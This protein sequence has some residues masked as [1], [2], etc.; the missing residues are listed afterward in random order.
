[1][2]KIKLM[3]LVIAGALVL[4][5]CNAN[6]NGSGKYSG[7]GSEHGGN[8]G[9]SGSNNVSGSWSDA[10]KAIFTNNLY[11]ID[12][13]Y[14]SIEGATALTYDAENEYASKTAPNCTKS[15]LQDYASLFDKS[16]T[17][18]CVDDSE[19]ETYYICYEKSVST[20][21]GTRYVD[22][23]MYGGTYDDELEDY[24]VN[25]DGS[26]TFIMQIY[27]PYYYEWP[28]DF[29]DYVLEVF[30]ITGTI[31]AYNGA[32]YYELNTSWLLFGY[33]SVY[34]Y[35]DDA[36]AEATYDAALTSAGYVNQG[37]DPDLG[38]PTYVNGDITIVASYD[39][40]Y[41]SLDIS[42]MLGGS[43]GG[44]GGG[45]G[46]YE[47]WPK[48]VVDDVLTLFGTTAKI[49][50]FNDAT[51]YEVD[52]EDLYDYGYIAIYCYTEDEDS[53]TKYG[54]ELLKAGFTFEGVDSYGYDVYVS[55]DE[56]IDVA[57]AYDDEYEDLDIY[58]ELYDSTGGGSSYEG[59]ADIC[60]N[61]ANESQLK[62]KNGN[63]SVWSQDGFTFTVKKG[64]ATVDVGNASYF[65]NPLRLYT[66][67]VVEMTFTGE[68]PAAVVVTVNTTSDKST[69]ANFT[70]GISGATVSASGNVVTL[71]PTGN[72][73]TTTISGKQA[74]LDMI[75]VY[76]AK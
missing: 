67:Q 17:S 37:V 49:P 5:G 27:D 69:V 58:I 55:E 23:L 60:L 51:E 9:N 68:I 62:T 56:V 7:G 12:V 15:L 65:S 61:F 66:N 11:G 71:I 10:E 32:D 18:Y 13:P 59:D 19:S 76:Y 4:A 74:H 47:T 73:I 70:S 26:G 40:D 64:K 75:E 42:I 41:K 43:G 57:I 45:E 1:M 31:P 36:N 30:E 52:D 21:A 53:V 48:D 54:A 39:S 28:A 20:S 3:S 38:V 50:A 14:M 44:S 8:S 24:D 2:K 46:V 6:N 25:Y 29:I 34:C 33:M 72:T 16:W 63:E 22:V 35:K